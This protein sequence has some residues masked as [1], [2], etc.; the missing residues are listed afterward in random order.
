MENK[1]E[2][3][4]KKKNRAEIE[5]Y[6]EEMLNACL[7]GKPCSYGI[8]DEC[9]ITNGYYNEDGEDEEDESE[10]QTNENDKT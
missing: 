4:Y 8:C 6:P 7:K 5:A 10:K 9:P 1:M 3:N 2:K